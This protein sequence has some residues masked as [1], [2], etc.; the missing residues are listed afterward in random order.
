MVIAAV[1]S[2]SVFQLACCV[3]NLPLSS[4]MR[5][6]Y[7]KVKDAWDVLHS[8]DYLDDDYYY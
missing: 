4:Y 5:L 1:Q 6:E 2:R 3:I 8:N 7:S